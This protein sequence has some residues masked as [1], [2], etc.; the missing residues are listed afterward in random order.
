MCPPI[1]ADSVST[2][3]VIYTVHRSPKNIVKWKKQAFRTFKNSHQVRTGCNMVKSSNPNSPIT[4]LI[5]LCPKYS[6]FLAELASILLL[7]FSLF[8]LVAAISVFIFGKPLFIDHTLPYFCMLDEYRVQYYPQFHVT[9]VVLGMYYP[10]IWGPTYTQRY[11]CGNVKS[12]KI[13]IFGFEVMT[14]I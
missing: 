11:C 12:H 8:A 6:H 4:W 14:V 13:T 3:S 2:F 9:M 5:F 10:Q 7:A 1:S